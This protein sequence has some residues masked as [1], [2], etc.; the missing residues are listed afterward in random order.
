MSILNIFS[1]AIKN[2]SLP[3]KV[4][5]KMDE[6]HHKFTAIPVVNVL[7]DR[8]SVFDDIAHML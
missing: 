5:F 2:N 1:S 7:R 3:A 6:L 8:I 4:P